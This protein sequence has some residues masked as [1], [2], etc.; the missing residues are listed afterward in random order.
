MSNDKGYG[1]KKIC[2]CIVCG[3]DVQVT[4]FASA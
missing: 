1:D 3:V 4:K 2:K